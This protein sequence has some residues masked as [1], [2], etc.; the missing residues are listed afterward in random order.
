MPIEPPLAGPDVEPGP[1]LI[2]RIL[3][4][5]WQSNDIPED[6]R[7]FHQSWRTHNPAWEF[8]F[9]TDAGARN[10]IATGY[11]WFLETYDA[12]QAPVMR[13]DSLRYFLLGHYG[14]VYADMDYECLRPL[15]EILQG[16]ELFWSANPTSTRKSLKCVSPDWDGCCAM[17]LWRPCPGMHSGNTW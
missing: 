4:Q 15:D 17:R 3:H 13:A 5:T 9:W 7:A 14:G 1:I 16:R 12:Y 6:W 8:M 2:P 11:P 10:F